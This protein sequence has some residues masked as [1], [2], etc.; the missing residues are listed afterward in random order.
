MEKVESEEPRV[1]RFRIHNGQPGPINLLV[2]PWGDV[3]QMDSG[4]ALE[5][6]AIGPADGSLDCEITGNGFT[7][8]GWAG[9]VVK[10][11]RDGK[12]IVPNSSG[13]VPVPGAPPGKSIRD[14]VGWMNK[15]TGNK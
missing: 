9:S 5:I 11:L 10:I 3:H 8:F 6:V 14:F 4:D 1:D 2:E 13:S 15:K 12:E 7:I